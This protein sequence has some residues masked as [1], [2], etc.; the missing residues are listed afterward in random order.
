[1]SVIEYHQKFTDLSYYCLEITGNPVKMFRYFKKGTHKRLRYL[2]TFTPY[3]LPTKNSLSFYFVLK[4][5]RMLLIM[6]MM[7]R[8]IVMLRRII[9]GDNH[10][11][12]IE[13]LRISREAVTVQ[14]RLA[15]SQVPI[16]LE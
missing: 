1:M 2:M 15:V 16:P 14:D 3:S 6:T 13:K 11:L 12:V 8:I 9:T 7:K 5:P 10:P 4:I